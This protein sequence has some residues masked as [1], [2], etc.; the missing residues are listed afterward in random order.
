MVSVLPCLKGPLPLPHTATQLTP[1]K[2]A[3]ERGNRCGIEFEAG[4]G[5]TVR[6]YLARENWWRD[7]P[8]RRGST[9]IAATDRSLEASC[10]YFVLNANYLRFE[11]WLYRRQPG[12]E[13]AVCISLPDL[14]TSQLLRLDWSDLLHARQN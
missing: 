2:L 11:A 13:N 14:L 10:A 1:Q 4:L 9:R 7:A 8:T 3:G 6:W 12:L 5:Q